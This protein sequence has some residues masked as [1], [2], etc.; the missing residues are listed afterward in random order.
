MKEPSSHW[1]EIRFRVTLSNLFD[2][3]EHLEYDTSPEEEEAKKLL[4]ELCR[5]IAEE[6]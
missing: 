4:I 1:A 3:K 6:K 5:K 2:C